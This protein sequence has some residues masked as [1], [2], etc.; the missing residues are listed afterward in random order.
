[1]TKA[2]PSGTPWGKA[3]FN[4][5]HALRSTNLTPDPGHPTD[6]RSPRGQ[7]RSELQSFRPWCHAKYLHF[8]RK[9]RKAILEQLWISLETAF[10]RVSQLP[11]IWDYLPFSE[12]EIIYFMGLWILQNKKKNMQHFYHLDRPVTTCNL[13]FQGTRCKTWETY[14][15]ER[16]TKP[17]AGGNWD[18]H[19]WNSSG[20]HSCIV[21]MQK[22][23]VSWDK[24]DIAIYNKYPHLRW[25]FTAFFLVCCSRPFLSW[26]TTHHM[27]QPSSL[28]LFSLFS[29]SQSSPCS[30][31]LL[32]RLWLGVQLFQV[33]QKGLGG[34]EP[35]NRQG[36][37]GRKF[38][39]WSWGWSLNVPVGCKV[40][41][42]GL[43]NNHEL[44][45][46]ITGA[47][48][49]AKDRRRVMKT[50]E[51]WTDWLGNPGNHTKTCTREC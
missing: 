6:P 19:T 46:S 7:C 45:P 30:P 34:F 10:T 26:N 27:P 33:R 21:E 38:R 12:C 17:C 37:V 36:S 23:N 2:I 32:G 4:R 28:F 50:Y 42:T 13:F 14:T 40:K 29:S 1:M 24:T 8:Q 39:G 43:A 9:W 47:C 16:F 31:Q 3:W 49:G 35:T 51:R 48:P 15:A 22:Q 20:F 41:F 5:I 11:A 18:L 44:L 25:V